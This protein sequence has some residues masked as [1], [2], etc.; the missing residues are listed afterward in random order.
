M[1]FLFT[2]YIVAKVKRGKGEKWKGEKVKRWKNGSRPLKVKGWKGEKMAA[3][4]K[5]ER[6]EK[7]NKGLRPLKV[8]RGKSE[9]VKEWKGETKAHAL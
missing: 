9:K 8:K 7:W 6:V 2:H 3:P 5:G 1:R 4:F